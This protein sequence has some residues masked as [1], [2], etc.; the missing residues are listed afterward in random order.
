MNGEDVEKDLADGTEPMGAHTVRRLATAEA[1]LVGDVQLL[2]PAPGVRSSMLLLLMLLPTARVGKT[3]FFL[4]PSPVFF[5]VFFWF[6]WGFLG[7]LGFWV[8]ILFICP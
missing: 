8:F 5:F 4:K 1:A 3:R 2:V 7:F 6:F